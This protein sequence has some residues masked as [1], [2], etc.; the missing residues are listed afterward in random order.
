MFFP[1]KGNEAILKALDDIDSFIN[2]NIN[3][4]PQIE[5]T[6]SGFNLEIKNKLEKISSSLRI[7]NDEELK[8]Y[9][10]IMLISE[11]LSDGNINDKI[12][13][14]KTS[15]EKLNYIAKTFNNL[16][17]HLKYMVQTIL[18]VLAEY[19]KHDYLRK[20]EIPK[21]KGEF[22]MLIEGVN[23]LRGTITI[24]LKENKENGL[25]LDRTSDILLVNVDKLNQSSN[26]AAVSLEQSAAAMEQ[27]TSN[28]K[29]NTENISKMAKLSDELITATNTGEDLA[30]QTTVAME[31]INTQVNS[32]S[33]AISI[34]DQIAFQ[35]NILSLNAAVEAA[36]AGEAGRGFAVV[37]AEVRNL[38]SRS[39]EAAK[40]IKNI[41]EIATIKA[42]NGKNI[43]NKMIS[44]Y[45]E[46]SE[47]ISHTTNIIQDIQFASKEQ[48]DGIVQINDAINLLDL[49]TQVN[50]SIATESHDVA[51]ITDRISKL[52]VENANKKQFEGKDEI[53]IKVDL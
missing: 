6:C 44:G 47:N 10:E 9:G 46:L 20:V 15:N 51:I 22:K 41:V 17:D 43:A 4:L 19:S 7:K 8:V 36:T 12:Y 5:G 16:V 34:I 31:E 53:K 26:E 21:L 52:I 14:T 18:D 38:A 27:I 2:N 32:I 23:T 33:D 3:S 25:T 1:N 13:H 39:A 42:N 37:A 45:R 30:N 24:M 50:A 40:E 11:K 48:L 49:Q 29:N 35:T 28:I